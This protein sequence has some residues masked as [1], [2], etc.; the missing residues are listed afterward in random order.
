MTLVGKNGLLVTDPG[1]NLVLTMT[2][3][4]KT[5]EIDNSQ[6]ALMNASIVKLICWSTYSPKTGNYYIV[7]AAA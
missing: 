3:S 6:S 4:S 1:R 5:G 7:A 2:Y